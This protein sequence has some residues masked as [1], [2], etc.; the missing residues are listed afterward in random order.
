MHGFLASFNPL[1]ARYKS[2]VILLGCALSF[3][4]RINARVIRWAARG[5]AASFPSQG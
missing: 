5:G 3:S 1:F 4:G 2:E